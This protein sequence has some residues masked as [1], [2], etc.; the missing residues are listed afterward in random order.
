MRARLIA[1]QSLCGH[2]FWPSVFH[3]FPILWPRSSVTQGEKEQSPQWFS[4]LNLF[5]IL[6]QR[7]FCNS[8]SHKKVFN[9][10]PLTFKKDTLL[11]LVIFYSLLFWITRSFSSTLLFV[12]CSVKKWG[13]LKTGC[14]REYAA[15]ALVCLYLLTFLQRAGES[16]KRESIIV[17]PLCLHFLAH[18]DVFIFIR[19]RFPLFFLFSF[20]LLPNRITLYLLP[21]TSFS[22]TLSYLFR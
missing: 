9:I 22:W 12:F 18:N 2:Y 7:G 11:L 5:Q 17:C 3:D 14:I 8:G 4:L 13:V 21:L 10:I 20:F 15:D 6:R 19:K 16:I 1:C